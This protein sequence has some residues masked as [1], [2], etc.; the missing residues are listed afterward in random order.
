MLG[1]AQTASDQRGPSV[2]NKSDTSKPP[3]RSVPLTVKVT[4][5]ELSALSRAA[6]VVTWAAERAVVNAAERGLRK[7]REAAKKHPELPTECK[8]QR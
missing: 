5:P 3:E 1:Y 6:V 4:I 8:G 2:A 7:V